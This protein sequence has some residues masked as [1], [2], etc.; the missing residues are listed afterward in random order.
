MACWRIESK[1]MCIWGIFGQTN[2]SSNG[3][4]GASRT[5][6][7][8]LFKGE[9]DLH[10]CLFVLDFWIAWYYFLTFTNA[11]RALQPLLAS[12]FFV[13]FLFWWNCFPVASAFY[14]CPYLFENP[15]VKYK[16]FWFLRLD[17]YISSILDL[18]KN[19]L[20]FVSTTY[21][22]ALYHY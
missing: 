14:G 19:V 7:N 6:K 8:P 17:F 11:N 9:G 12:V 20:H 16:L 10:V 2:S 21:H 5:R 4:V 1:E 3:S 18:P 13:Y 15:R 22:H